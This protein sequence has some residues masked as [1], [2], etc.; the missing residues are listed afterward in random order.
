MML[1]YLLL[2][3]Y[4]FGTVSAAVSSFSFYDDGNK[5][6]VQKR[7]PHEKLDLTIVE[8]KH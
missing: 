3:L 2:S 7:H 6:K 1:T 4:I 8:N 5:T